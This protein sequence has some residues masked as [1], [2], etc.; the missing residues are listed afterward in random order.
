LFTTG[1]SFIGNNEYAYGASTG[2]DDS[3]VYGFQRNG[4]GDLTYLNFNVPIPNYDAAYLAAAD[5]KNHLAISVLPYTSPQPGP[6][7]ARLAVYTIESSGDLSTNSTT[8]NMPSVEVNNVI[9]LN[10]S[11]SGALLAVGGSSGL[12]VFHF[13]GSSPITH[14]TGLLTIDEIDQIFWDNDNHLYAISHSHG[15]LFV[16]KATPTSVSQAPGSPHSVSGVEN[17]SVLSK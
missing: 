16:F 2:S 14:Y 3:Q 8:E 1:L 13:N 5:P 10:M 6:G 9:A 17:L 12:Q 11:P 7:P 4:N 15:K